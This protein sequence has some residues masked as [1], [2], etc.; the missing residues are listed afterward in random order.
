MPIDELKGK[1]L[2]YD[3]TTLLEH[4]LGA[5]KPAEMRMC[6]IYLNI[7]RIRTFDFPS[8]YAGVA[9]SVQMVNIR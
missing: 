9:K 2:G 1:I 8:I 7:F 6:L 5:G 3:I 4:K